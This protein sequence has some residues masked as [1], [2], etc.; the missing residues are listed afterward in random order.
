[1]CPVDSV[2]MDL[3]L[4]LVIRLIGG[5]G[6]GLVV[7]LPVNAVPPFIGV[8]YPAARYELEPGEGE[9]RTY[10]HVTLN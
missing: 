1:M 5:P 8:G 4:P 9:V 2:A 10:R 6:D 3:E 7:T